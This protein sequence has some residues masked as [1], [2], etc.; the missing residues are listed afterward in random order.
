MGHNSG[1]SKKANPNSQACTAG[2]SGKTLR[3]EPAWSLEEMMA[4]DAG[5][6]EL[7]ELRQWAERV[8][9]QAG[10]VLEG[11]FGHVEAREKQ[12]GD[13]VTDADGASQRAIA[14]AIERSYPD[15]TLLAEEDGV[16]PDPSKPWRW[17]VDPLDGTINFAHGLPIWCVSIGLEHA[18]E[19]VVGV[20]HVPLLATTYSASRGGGATANGRAMRTS[21]VTALKGSLIT[22]GLPTD[23]AADAARQLALMGRFSTG[24]H[25]VRRTG[26]TAWNLAH[27]AAGACEVFYATD[28]HPW[29]VA[30]GVLLVRE[31]GGQVSSLTGGPYDLYGQGILA[32]NGKVHAEAAAAIHDAW[33]AF[34]NG[35]VGRSGR[36]GG[37]SGM[38]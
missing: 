35:G 37:V 36:G 3:A 13:L 30:A 29:D 34:Q 4:N 14:A 19:L 9:I 33:P 18:G 38:L 23:F 21:S 28:I 2:I 8:A 15:H 12:P 20:I 7:R 27:V 10:K 24:T 17:V 5:G 6:D 22:T 26:S 16:V 1:F 11:F 25:S 31:A 32:S